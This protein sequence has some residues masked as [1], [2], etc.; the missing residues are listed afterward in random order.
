MRPSNA[1]LEVIGIFLIVLMDFLG[2]Q[3]HR[4]PDEE[5]RDMLRQ[6]MIDTIVR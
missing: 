1:Y 2:E 5:M 4:I 3:R 6:Q